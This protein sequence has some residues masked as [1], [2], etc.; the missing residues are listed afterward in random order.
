MLN[1]GQIAGVKI[2]V[3]EYLLLLEG[4]VSVLRDFSVC[5]VFRS[6]HLNYEKR[7]K[8]WKVKFVNI[9]DCK[10]VF[11]VWFLLRNS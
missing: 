4:V 8:L 9:E 2:A 3:E 10:E 11:K 1:F 7:F 6:F 5:C